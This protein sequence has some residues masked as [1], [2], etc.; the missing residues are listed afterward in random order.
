[1]WKWTA[2]AALAALY[3]ITSLTPAMAYSRD[4]ILVN[5]TG[6]TITGVYLSAAG[7]PRWIR[8]QG[9]DWIGPRQNTRISFDNSGPCDMQLRVD[10]ANGIHSEWR[11][12]FNFCQV[13]VVDIQYNSL[14][15]T[16]NA[17]Y[18]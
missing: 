14:T 1:M 3:S 11:S 16:I 4:F 17:D 2:T 12:G 6:L 5:D 18:R 8:S 13:S 7:Y 9:A 10:F 15:R